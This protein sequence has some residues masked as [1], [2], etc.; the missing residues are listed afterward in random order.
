[1]DRSKNN[2]EHT[3]DDGRTGTTGCKLSPAALSERLGEVGRLLENCMETRQLEDGVAL[4][5]PGDEAWAAHLLDLINA[6]R[7]CCPSLAF[8][9]RFE[10]GQG[11]I[12]IRILGINEV[13]PLGAILGSHWRAGR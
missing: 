13:E 2:D 5:F 3:G 6:E 9:L 11:S 8:E 10:P 7:R 12:W 4:R 1:M